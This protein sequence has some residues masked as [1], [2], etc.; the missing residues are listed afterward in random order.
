[1]AFTKILITLTCRAKQNHLIRTNRT[2]LARQGHP[3]AANVYQQDELRGVRIVSLFALNKVSLAILCSGNSSPTL[4]SLRLCVPCAKFLI[5][6]HNSDSRNTAAVGAR[7]SRSICTY[8]FAK[9]NS[10]VMNT[11]TKSTGGG[12]SPA[13][14]NTWTRRQRIARQLPFPLHGTRP[15]AL[16]LQFTARRPLPALIPFQ[17]SAL[18]RRLR[19]TPAE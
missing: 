1:M 8:D 3:F 10:F 11:C 12:Y 16:P 14:Q 5:P 2:P 13:L 19:T 17:L 6:C 7:N 15:C 18:N 4:C 9:P